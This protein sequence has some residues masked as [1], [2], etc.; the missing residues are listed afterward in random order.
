MKKL[1]NKGITTIEVIICFVLVVVITVSMYSTISNFNQ[2]RTLESYKSE[3]YTYKNTLTK[4]IQDDFIKKGLTH[5]NYS[6]VSTSG[7]TVYTVDAELKDGDKRKLVI[8]Q[9]LAKSTYHIGGKEGV[10]DYF[11]IEYGSPDELIEYPLPELGESKTDAGDIIKD[12]SL[13]N[14]MIEIASNNVLSI[15]IGFYHPELSTRYSINIISPID[16]ISTG[17]DATM[18]F[19]FVEEEGDRYFVQFNANGGVGAPGT[20]AVAVG[21]RFEIPDIIP[22][23][24]GYIF[25]GWYVNGKTDKIYRP[26]E[27]VVDMVGKNETIILYAKWINETFSF[28]PLNNYYEFEVPVN[29]KYKL[30]AWGAQGG[31]ATYKQD[32]GNH[33][34][35]G[36][37]ASG[38]INLNVGD[39][40]YIYTGFAGSY[41]KGT[42]KAVFNGG[43]LGSMAETLYS[44]S[45]GGATHI[46]TTRGLLTDV[47]ESNILLV[48]AGG[49]GAGGGKD[50]LTSLNSGSDAS[51]GNGGGSVGGLGTTKGKKNSTNSTA[52]KGKGGTAKKSNNYGVGGGG[53][54]FKSG[55]SGADTAYAGG[56]GGTSFVSTKLTN[57]KI[58]CY[59]CPKSNNTTSVKKQS[60]TAIKETAKTGNGYVK[61]TL[62]EQR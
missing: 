60:S 8:T 2:K 39:R 21:D 44:G 58:S 27:Y 31:G 46:A 33:A 26:G 55:I 7:K 53:A 17:S 40:L 18:G 12:L 56:N 38:E 49:G 20:K 41:G 37:Y 57:P 59:E 6:K 50:R 19:K 32:E 43:G 36:A 11:M 16:Y 42:Q 24:S 25:E 14:I 30:E 29:G 22:T 5:A 54:G 62:L 4:T 23:R 15:Y 47:S 61:I 45:G 51:G 34:G 13:N 3:I 28:P 35:L 48:A 9:V 52:V 10:D 1:N